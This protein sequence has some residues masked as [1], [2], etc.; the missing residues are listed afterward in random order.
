MTSVKLLDVKIHEIAVYYE[1]VFFCIVF[2]Q[3][4]TARDFSYEPNHQSNVC[5]TERE[6]RISTK[7]VI[8]IFL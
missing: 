2:N 6:L 4:L 8:R 5:M 3:C 7:C 1:S